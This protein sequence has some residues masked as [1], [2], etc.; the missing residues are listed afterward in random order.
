MTVSHVRRTYLDT[1]EAVV[2]LLS[3]PEVG[4]HWD[5]ASVL[6]AFAVSGLAGHLARA[7]FQV[8]DYLDA[9]V[10]G[11]PPIDAAVYFAELDSTADIDNSLNLSVRR[12][13]DE[14]GAGG[15]VEL[16]KRATDRLALVRQALME[17]PAGRHIQVLG[18]RVLLLDEYL[19]TRLVEMVV[20]T[21]DLTLSIG[22]GVGLPTDAITIATDTIV[23]SAR[24]RHGDLAFLRG[25]TRRERDDVNATRVF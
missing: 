23:H 8:D 11:T 10:P 4:E 12:R 18:N 5:E 14:E 19:K 1:G 15:P 16:A 20:H 25:M 6:A 7:I 24:I 3:K 9:S 17:A 21:E 2:E 22:A 13:G